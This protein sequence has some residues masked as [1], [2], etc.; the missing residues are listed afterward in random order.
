MKQHCVAKILLAI[1]ETFSYGNSCN[2]SSCKIS[3]KLAFLPCMIWATYN[4]FRKTSEN[5]MESRPENMRV[6]Y[7]LFYILYFKISGNAKQISRQVLRPRY[8]LDKVKAE[9][10]D[11]KLK[12]S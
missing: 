12:L 3:H 6:F 1:S 11:R 8:F 9:V 2:F 7:I 10:I 5:K 4:P